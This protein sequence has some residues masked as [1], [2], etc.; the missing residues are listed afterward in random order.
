MIYTYDL[1]YTILLLHGS[2][3]HVV[4][5]DEGDQT[6]TYDQRKYKLSVL[7]VYLGFYL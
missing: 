5:E 1:D 3:I 2:Y 6:Y 7:V 4:G